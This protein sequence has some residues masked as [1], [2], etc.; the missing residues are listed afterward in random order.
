MAKKKEAMGKK[1]VAMAKK[2]G[3]MAIA[4]QWR[5]VSPLASLEVRLCPALYFFPD[6]IATSESGRLFWG[7]GP[8]VSSRLLED[9]DFS[10][11]ETCA[12]WDGDV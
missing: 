7:H 10:G 5:R 12:L 3:A 1:M 4:V 9:G 2:R 8:S 6:G 11:D